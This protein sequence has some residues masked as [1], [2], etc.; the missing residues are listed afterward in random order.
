VP[1]GFGVIPWFLNWQ[2]WLTAS[3]MACAGFVYG[4]YVGDLGGAARVQQLFDAY[5]AQTLEQ[6]LAAQVERQ[7]QE[8]AMQATN[9]KVTADYVS[10]QTATGVAVRALDADR[11][12]LQTA[13]AAYRGATGKDSGTGLQVDDSA[14]VG[15]FSE[16][17]DRYSTLAGQFDQEGDTLRSLQDYVR[18]VVKP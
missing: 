3:V 13:L 18:D 8:S 11:M 16:C 17:I 4:H 6:A 2:A 14:L 15:S 1:Q 5:R 12:R 10:L 9:Q 7:A